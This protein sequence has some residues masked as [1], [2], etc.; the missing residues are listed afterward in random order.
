MSPDQLLGEWPSI[1]TS[2]GWKRTSQPKLLKAIQTLSRGFTFDKAS[3]IAGYLGRP[4]LLEA[5]LW[6]FV[7]LN[8]I[9]LFT[10]LRPLGTSVPSQVTDW[11]SGPLTAVM[12]LWALFPEWRRQ[13]IGWTVVDPERPALEAGRRL[14]AILG[15]PSSWK[16]SRVVGRLGT[17]LRRKADLILVSHALNE[18]NVSPAAALDRLL[19]AAAPHARLALV[20]P[21]TRLASKRLTALRDQ[22]VGRGL[23]V[24]APC[25]HHAPC[26]ARSEARGGI[27]CHFP[28]VMPLPPWLENLAKDLGFDTEPPPFSHLILAHA[29]PAGAPAESLA[30]VMSEPLQGA[31]GRVL[32]YACCR[33]GFVVLEGALGASRGEVVPYRLRPRRDP[34]TQRPLA[35]PRT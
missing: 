8:L 21:G 24:Q 14:L 26:P 29:P 5:Y 15:Q 34:K 16:I 9:K 31:G 1:L 17:P 4:A 28:S 35:E 2:A 20:E 30:R 25:T 12:A 18:W 11:G 7:P 33:E 6:W 10:A 13:P 19:D 22:A 27:F 3:R 23:V 32:R